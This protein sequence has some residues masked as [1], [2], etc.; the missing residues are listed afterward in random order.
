MRTE[1][2]HSQKTGMAFALHFAV[3]ILACSLL[4]FGIY[5]L[6]QPRRIPNPGLAAYRPPPATVINYPAAS[7]VAQVQSTTPEPVTEVTSSEPPDETTGQAVQIAEPA[8][9]TRSAPVV[10]AKR[11]AVTRTAPAINASR[12]RSAPTRTHVPSPKPEGTPGG[13]VAAYPGY[14]TIH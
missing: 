12:V 7:Q 8:P 1:Y 4:G 5:G 9:S 2:P 13:M 11:P 10:E 14:A 6:F 3:C